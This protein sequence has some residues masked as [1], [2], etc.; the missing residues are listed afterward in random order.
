MY[1]LQ[2]KSP[3]MTLNRRQMRIVVGLDQVKVSDRI[4]R[5]A[6]ER[7]R[8][9]RTVEVGG[10]LIGFIDERSSRFDSYGTLRVINEIPSGPRAERTATSLHG[11]LEYQEKQ[12]ER[13]FQRDRRVH[14]LGSWHSHVANGMQHLS[15]GDLQS[16]QNMV[17]SE[18]HRHSYYF[19]LLLLRLPVFGICDHSVFNYFRFYLIHRDFHTICFELG[20]D[21]IT[22]EEQPEDYSNLIQD[23]EVF[24]QQRITVLNKE[25]AGW[26]NSSTGRKFLKNDS[27][28]MDSLTETIPILEQG[29]IL[30]RRGSTSGRIVRTFF[31]GS[32]RI[33]YQYPEETLNGRITIEVFMSGDRTDYERVLRVKLSPVPLRFKI[34]RII[35]QTLSE[36]NE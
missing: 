20:R 35:I 26:V 14:H 30:L 8:Y 11:D 22:I 5:K 36:M 18:R 6:I 3:F 2:H 32:H 25:P 13:V 7:A 28:I 31:L 9:N 33:E 27:K 16:Y 24:Q 4:L 17:C 34:F 12:F 23:Y 15:N 10:I 29:P 21:C 19:A 1:K